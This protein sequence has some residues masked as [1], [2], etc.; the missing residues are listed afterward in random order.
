MKRFCDL[1]VGDILQIYE[2]DSEEFYE[3]KIRFLICISTDVLQIITENIS[4][5]VE[6]L[7]KDFIKIEY[8]N[9]S[10]SIDRLLLELEQ[11]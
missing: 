9:I 6:P 2:E 1:K 5:I 8:L 10:T 11:C 4:F 3:E 7:D